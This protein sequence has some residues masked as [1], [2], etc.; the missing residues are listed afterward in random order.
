MIPF[1]LIVYSDSGGMVLA[2]DAVWLSNTLESSD[3]RNSS[4][5]PPKH[6]LAGMANSFRWLIMS[7]ACNLPD[8]QNLDMVH[9]LNGTLATF[10]NGTIIDPTNIDPQ[11]CNLT[12]CPTQLY[13]NS[14]LTVNLA[15]TTY[16]PSM[17]GNTFYVAIF[18]LVLLAQLGLGIWK[19]TWGFMVAISSGVLLE[20]IGYIGRIMLSQNPF[21]DNPFLMSLVCLTIGP[22]F[23]SAGV[24]L[25]LARL[26]V[27][28]GE[29]LSSFKPRT[30]T[31]IFITS[32]FVALV[33]Q[34]AGGAIASG[35]TIQSSSQT[36]INIMI[37]GL[38]FQ[39]VS[40]AFFSTLALHFAYRVRNARKRPENRFRE[41]TESLWLRAFQW[42]LSF[43]TLTIFI[44]SC[45]RV[46]ELSGGF[47]GSLANNQV[48]FMIL[49]GAMIIM[50][51][52]ALTACHPGICFSG[53]WTAATW[54]VTAK[55]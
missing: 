53:S 25:C 27:I 46:A 14:T 9:F 24:Y 39:V 4:M 5:P 34:A 8:R 2:D 1:A 31:I 43:A 41:I 55:G 13:I 37:A 50:A 12:I 44:R 22:A 20:I 51:V 7:S 33:L 28:H 10:P 52:L 48:S 32:D 40:L 47:H 45:F 17:A 16:I 3:N 23:L 54:S 42:T 26:V 49:E 19:K 6:N 35:A 21:P 29:D 11:A 36:G 38:S 30:Y 15:H 18:G